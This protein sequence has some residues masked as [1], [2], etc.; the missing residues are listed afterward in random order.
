MFCPHLFVTGTFN[1]GNYKSCCANAEWYPEKGYT[2]Y[3]EWWNH[4]IIRGM[5]LQVMAGEIPKGCEEC[6][7][8]KNIY[9]GVGYEVAEYVGGDVIEYS[10]VDKETGHVSAPPVRLTISASNRCNLKCNFCS[11]YYSHQHGGVVTEIGD[12][13]LEAIK[14]LAPT[15]REVN[16]TGGEPFYDKKVTRKLLNVLKPY[17]DQIKLIINTNGTVRWKDWM[18]EIWEFKEVILAFSVDSSMY[19]HVK[20]RG[21]VQGNTLLENWHHVH[22]VVRGNPEWD[23]RHMIGLHCSPGYEMIEGLYDM[24]DELDDLYQFKMD[25]MSIMPVLHP[26]TSAINRP[27][28]SGIPPYRVISNAY[29]RLRWHEDWM[30]LKEHVDDKEKALRV[31]GYIKLGLENLMKVSDQPWTDPRGAGD[32]PVRVYQ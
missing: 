9:H 27:L 14:E 20:H 24:M 22:K 4:P 32:I 11:P 23:K 5:R 29:K 10:Q 15:L 3:E 7:E 16:I 6:I 13:E 1:S 30:H 21:M 31:I 17:R 25:F 28:D 19:Y 2:N 12:V 26:F 8:Q 18:D